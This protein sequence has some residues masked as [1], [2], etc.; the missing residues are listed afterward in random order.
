LN[1]VNEGGVHGGE[2]NIHHNTNDFKASLG[3]RP[4]GIE[5]AS[6]VVGN[7]WR[8]KICDKITRQQLICPATNWFQLNNCIYAN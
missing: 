2:L 3:G 7:Q 8:D 4:L 1:Q 5:H 6:E